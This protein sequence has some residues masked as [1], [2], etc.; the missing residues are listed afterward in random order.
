MLYEAAGAKGYMITLIFFFSQIWTRYEKNLPRRS[1]TMT[2]KR[3]TRT[4]A[5]KR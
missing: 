4:N 2:G 5:K 3:K 1:L